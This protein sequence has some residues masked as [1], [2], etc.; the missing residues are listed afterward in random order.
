MK[1]NWIKGRQPDVNYYKLP[2]YS[3]KL[4]KLGMDAYILKYIAPTYLPEHTDPVE[5]ANHWRINIKLK[6]YSVFYCQGRQPSDYFIEFFR[7]DL[8]KHSLRVYTNTLKLSLGFAY[9]K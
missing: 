2:L 7:P 5:S 9:Y 8:L 1:L 4:G 3:F 6:G